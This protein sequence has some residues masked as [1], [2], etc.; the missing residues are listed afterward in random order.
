MP[1][2]L[3]ETNAMAG[4]FL[5][6]FFCD[7]LTYSIDRA[8]IFCMDTLYKEH[9]CKNCE[10]LLFRGLLIGSEIEIKCKRCKELNKFTGESKDTLICMNINCLNR[11]ST[12]K[13][14]K[15]EEH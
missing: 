2:K 14:K 1:C 10:K 5:F 3:L 15:A 12:K 6:L 9:R 13:N 8:I 4:I 11:L 7:I